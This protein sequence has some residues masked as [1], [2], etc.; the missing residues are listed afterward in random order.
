MTKEKSGHLQSR[1]KL[2][3]KDYIIIMMACMGT[4]FC[5]YFFFTAL[6][7]YAIKISGSNVFGGMMVVTY[8]VAALVARPFAGIISDKFGRV[9]LLI[10]G[11]F[12]C[13][14]ACFL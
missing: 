1:E 10:A 6:P 11:A 7:L 2:L 13:A 5:N 14:V 9:K 3:S 12:I 8:S 4:A